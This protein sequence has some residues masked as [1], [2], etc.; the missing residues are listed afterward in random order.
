MATLRGY[1]QWSPE[2]EGVTLT[3]HDLSV[4]APSNN[5]GGFFRRNRGKPY[6]RLLN[7]VSGAVKPGSLVALMGASGAGK[8]TL[9]NA[10]ANR[11]PVGVVVDGDIRVNGRPVGPFMNKLCGYVP[12][13]DLFV[14]DLTVREHL[15]FMAWL[16]L[17]R[18]T[19][20]AER[21]RQV[22][23]LIS[24][25]GLADR[26]DTRI[27][28][29]GSEKV[30]S[31]GEKKRLAFASELLTNPAI[32]FCDE[33]TTGLDSYSA[34][35]IVHMMGAMAAQN[36][37]VLCTIHQPSS[38]VFSLFHELILLVDGRIAFMGSSENAVAFFARCPANYNPA[39]Y[40]IHALAVT[41]GDEE[42]SRVAVKAI[43]DQYTVSEHARAVDLLVHYERHLADSCEGIALMAGLCYVGTQLD[44]KGV[45]AIQGAL[46]IFVTENTF[47]PMYSVLALFPQ[48]MPLFMRE[49]HSGLY[50]VSAYY[51]S[52]MAA[53]LPGLIL[54]P[55][56]FVL[57]AYWLIG[58]RTTM[59]AVTMTAFVTVLTMNVSSACG[60]FFSTAF[61]STS[62]AMAF[63]IPFDYILM[64]TS[65]L[66]IKLSSLPLYIGW[67]RYLSWL[68]YSNEAMSIVQWEGVHN[69]TC[70]EVHRDLPCLS[71][72]SE[73][74]DNFSFSP[75]NL[76]LD[77][78]AML[79]LYT[80]FHTLGYICLA[81]RAKRT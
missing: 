53:M 11:N 56:L 48:E 1:G 31:G 58:L 33:P 16:R 41:P 40:L 14:R 5:E 18:R 32:L 77:V 68:M 9:M 3:W 37:T 65:G 70:D 19:S 39:D 61:E 63:L 71:D 46:F 78:I 59:Y 28:A 25:L 66:F 47:T 22:N 80:G 74:L 72:G 8:S 54:E 15:N 62:I 73:V 36:K 21:R 34:Q 67:V 51:L 43:C 38:E 13:E 26:A 81:A 69:I 57:V 42:R 12:Q 75:A 2:V 76:P 20:R 60:C 52:K 30:L 7:S 50:S 79:A 17:D 24:Y 49:H 6:K 23:E 35:K 64:A 10:L 29:T 55:M 45:Q 44:Q 4:Y 27:G